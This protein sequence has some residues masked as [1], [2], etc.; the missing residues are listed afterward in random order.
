VTRHSLTQL[1]FLFS[2][3]G[4]FPSSLLTGD[5]DLF[6]IL[7]SIW[8]STICC[9]CGTSSS[10]GSSTMCCLCGTSSTGSST[11]CCLCGTSSFAGSSTICCLW[12]TSSSLAG[13]AAGEKSL[14]GAASYTSS[15]FTLAAS[16]TNSFSNSTTFAY[17]I[18]SLTFSLITCSLAIAI[19]PI[20]F[21]IASNPS[22]KATK[23]FSLEFQILITTDS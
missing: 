20:E 8:S 21:K 10:A 5:K 12:G 17:G 14:F 13:S 1:S 2:S 16:C 19:A 11:M 9:L 18:S 15:F 7:S 23:S 22:R 6:G 3:T 4:P